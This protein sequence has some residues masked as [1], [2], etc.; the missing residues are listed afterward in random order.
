MGGGGGG[1]GGICLRE[2]K[3]RELA[4]GRGKGRGGGGGGGWTKS[5]LQYSH[6][7]SVVPGPASWFEYQVDCPQKR[8]KNLHVICVEF[9]VIL[10]QNSHQKCSSWDKKPVSYC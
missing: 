1:G 5:C 8:D 10:I 3:G 9:S 7:G 2:V 4:Q 6:P